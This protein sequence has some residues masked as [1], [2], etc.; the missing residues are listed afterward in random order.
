MAQAGRFSEERNRSLSSTV[1]VDQKPCP[2]LPRDF[3]AGGLV[4]NPESVVVNG[5]E[6]SLA[7][8]SSSLK[9]GCEFYSIGF[10]DYQREQYRPYSASQ[11]QRGL[12][13]RVRLQAWVDARSDEEIMLQ[14]VA[15]H[16]PYQPWC[17]ICIQTKG[18]EDPTPSGAEIFRDDGKPCVQLDWLY[19][20]GQNC[21]ALAGMAEFSLLGQKERFDKWKLW[22]AFPWS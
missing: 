6:L 4:G 18:K 8:S 10:C 5:Q 15:T 12:K 17:S 2:S 9:E 13:P 7:S 14:R 19:C 3:Q 22:C 11:L 1:E 16:L 20:G 21:P